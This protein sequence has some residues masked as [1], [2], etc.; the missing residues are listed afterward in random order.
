MA[1]DPDDLLPVSGRALSA[2]R[3]LSS[4]VRSF[5]SRY[6]F[7]YFDDGGV[8]GMLA[9]HQE[10]F[11]R[12]TR[13]GLVWVASLAGTVG[14]GWLLW[15]GLSKPERIAVAV[16]PPAVLLV[17]AV[18]AFVHIYRQG[19]RKLEH[20]FLVGYRHVLAA[21]LAHGTPVTHVPAWLTGRS[22]GGVEAAPLPPYTA[23]PGS[24]PPGNVQRLSHGGAATVP[25][26]SK[27]D[28]VAEYERIAEHG[29]WHD[30]AGWILIGAGCV[31]VGY[32]LVKDMPAAF[33]AVVLV[34]LGVWAWVAGYR[35]GKRK[36]ELG[37]EARRYVEQLTRAQAAGAVVP[38]LSP[39]LR[40]LLESPL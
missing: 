16:T 33:A 19:K 14:L 35:L 5:G 1:N 26:P 12:S 6:G 18:A 3:Q 13:G 38:E 10:A 8:R 24:P 31:G 22:D 30:E 40:K 27:P 20:P 4:V 17:L 34:G 21:A 11:R 32:A 9:E 39:Q 15:A 29:G 25:L 36:G 28:A 37:A 2:N 7:D 23:P